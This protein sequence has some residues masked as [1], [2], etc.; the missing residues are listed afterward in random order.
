MRLIARKRPVSF[1]WQM[2]VSVAELHACFVFYGSTLQTFVQETR[3]QE[4]V[5]LRVTGPSLRYKTK[6][7]PRRA[8]EKQGH[9]RRAGRNNTEKVFQCK[10]LL[11]TGYEST[12]HYNSVQ[13][14]KQETV[15]KRGKQLKSNLQS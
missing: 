14:T 1:V 4:Q 2:Q 3:S 10:K 13:N 11:D 5:M 8:K 12:I 6:Q 15:H 7:S 9:W